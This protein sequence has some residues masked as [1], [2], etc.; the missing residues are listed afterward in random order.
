M[1]L[2]L[3]D[4][5][6]EDHRFGFEEW[7]K[8]KATAE[9]GTC[10]ILEIDG[11]RLVQTK[12]IIRYIAQMH[13][14]Y[15]TALKDV[16]LMESFVDEVCDIREDLIEH[17][18]HQLTDKLAEHYAKMPTL[19]PL[20]EKRLNGNPARSGWVVG[21]NMT[22]ADMMLFDLLWNWFLSPD[23]KA[24][25]ADKVSKRLKEF[26]EFFLS[27]YPKMREYVSNRQSR[28]F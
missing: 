18:A 5:P 27:R 10:P 14:L 24:E 20:L 9:F 16:Y 11:H 15:P 8:L 23:R 22:L 1:M 26:A 12:S 19:L 6:F 21:G 13:G 4:V 17:S 3:T 25:H 2:H 7:M 28:P